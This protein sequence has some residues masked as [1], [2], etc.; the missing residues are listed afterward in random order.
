[1]ANMLSI[2]L[3]CL[4]GRG[5]KIKMKE[6]DTQLITHWLFVDWSTST[7]SCLRYNVS[8]QGAFV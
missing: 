8:Y 1:M 7:P 4:E 2:H 5:W 6:S 3:P